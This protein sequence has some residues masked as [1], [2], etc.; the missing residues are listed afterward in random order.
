LLSSPGCRFP[1]S[2]SQS[3]SA[4]AERDLPALVNLQL[5]GGFPTSERRKKSPLGR[6]RRVSYN[7]LSSHGSSRGCVLVI[8][9]GWKRLLNSVNYFLPHPS[10]PIY[11]GPRYGHS[12][13]ANL[14]NS[15]ESQHLR[16]SQYL[17]PAISA[18]SLGECPKSA[19]LWFVVYDDADQ[20][21]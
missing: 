15:S 12:R 10:T 11:D 18:P 20:S 6:V 14:S 16:N 5:S 13:T 9:L 4:I 3:A 2:S 19:S 17:Q 1:S 8:V 7:Q 21:V